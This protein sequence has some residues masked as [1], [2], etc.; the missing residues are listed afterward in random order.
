[1]SNATVDGEIVVMD[2]AFVLMETHFTFPKYHLPEYDYFQIDQQ[3]SYVQNKSWLLSRQEFTYY[4]KSNRQRL[5]GHTVA[6]F[7]DY[8]LNKQFAKRYFAHC[9]TTNKRKI[10]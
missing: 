5:S 10:F 9:P 2:S 8:E 3:Y 1:M 7:S 6:T 4:S